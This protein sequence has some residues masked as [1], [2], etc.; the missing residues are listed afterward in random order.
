MIKIE[1]STYSIFISESAIEELS[2]F[3]EAN[4][5]DHQIF[6][7]VDE[8]TEKHCLPLFS[9]LDNERLTSG[10]ALIVP[11]GEE[12]KS[13]DLL[14]G[15]AESLLELGATRKSIIINLGGGVVTDLGGFLASTFKRGIPF[16]NVPTSL[17]AMVDA[18]CGGKTG[19]NLG[20]FKNQLGTFSF[21]EA[22]FCSLNFLETLP[23]K[24][25]KSGYVEALK[26]GLIAEKK[27]WD[28][29]STKNLGQDPSV[30]I[31]A[32]SIGVK[33]SITIKDPYE[34]GERKKL[35][36]GHTIGH[37]IE[38][39]SH[40]K[41]NPLL[42]GEAIAM[43]IVIESFLSVF[44]ANLPK[45]ELDQIKTFIFSQ[46]K[47]Y[48]LEENDFDLMFNLMKSDKKNEKEGF[49]FTLLNGIGSSEIDFSLTEEEVTLALN[50]Y[51]SLR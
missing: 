6:I 21:P 45:D 20:P 32:Q 47:K 1:S 39:L 29:L 41:G 33:N 26:H 50:W 2:I 30:E 17:L 19:V 27:I 14:A 5:P 51:I 12:S 35:N 48:G 36:F 22:V 24:E 34:K 23:K 37:A 8:N 38:G 28:S 11:V 3:V 9:W 7:L 31:V 15:L 40:I 10:D 46:F 49:N 16:I 43:G 44:H 25:M 13:V 4:F 42:H 18:S